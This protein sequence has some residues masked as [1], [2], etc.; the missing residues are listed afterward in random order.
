MSGVRYSEIRTLSLGLYSPDGHSIK[1]NAMKF[2]DESVLLDC[3]ANHE[4][5]Y[6]HRHTNFHGIQRTWNQQLLQ[7]LGCT[8]KILKFEY[9]SRW[10]C[11][12]V[13]S[14]GSGCTCKVGPLCRDYGLHI[15]EIMLCDYF[16][17]SHHREDHAPHLNLVILIQWNIETPSLHFSRA[18]L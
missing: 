7:S 3:Y 18:L 4:G 11:S 16:L 17:S 9:N 14:P 8:S 10:S 2:C 13:W 5:E 12:K 15:A 1:L 6:F